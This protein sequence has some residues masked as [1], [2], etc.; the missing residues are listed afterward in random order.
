MFGLLQL[1]AGLFLPVHQSLTASVCFVMDSC[2]YYVRGGTNILL[3]AVGG[4]GLISRPVELFN[5]A[6]HIH[7]W[8]RFAAPS[9]SL[10]HHK[11]VDLVVS[12]CAPFATHLLPVLLSHVSKHFGIF[13]LVK[14]I[15]G[16][17]LLFRVVLRLLL[18]LV[19]E[20]S[21]R[22]SCA[23]SARLLHYNG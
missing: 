14:S 18:H 15:V 11:L 13:A 6:H 22:N 5:V 23:H 16:R 2:L 8:H 3:E 20:E 10:L 9:V 1:S 12:T 4:S 19:E 21:G 17:D 7:E